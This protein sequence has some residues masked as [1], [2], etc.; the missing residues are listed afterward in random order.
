MDSRLKSLIDRLN[1]HN[2]V[3]GRARDVFLAKEAERKHFEASL[4]KTALGKSHAEKLIN[5]QSSNEWLEFHVALARLESIY[6]FRKL[7]HEILSKEWISE[8]LSL[9][10]D[11]ETIRKQE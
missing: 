7:E 5:A 9:K 3:L 4:V 1:A 2:T 11:T 8:H 6:E 10:V